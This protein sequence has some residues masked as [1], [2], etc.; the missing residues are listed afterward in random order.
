MTA[1][2]IEIVNVD[3][4]VAE[5]TVRLA[6]EAI[7]S[8]TKVKSKTLTIE[9][10]DET[11]GVWA[12]VDIDLPNDANTAYKTS[13][14]STLKGFVNTQLYVNNKASVYVSITNEGDK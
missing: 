3:E 8:I 4:D 9:P 7:S 14:V 12:K 13:L 10:H 11:R 5:K 1:L 6:I 2:A